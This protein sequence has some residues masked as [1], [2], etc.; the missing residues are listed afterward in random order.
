MKI[1]TMTYVAKFDNQIDIL[2][3][4]ENGL[5]QNLD[6]DFFIEDKSKKVTK[7]G[8]PKKSFG[9]QITIKSRTMTFNLKIFFNKKIQVTGVKSRENLDTIFNKLEHLFKI[10]I[11]SPKLVMK[12]CVANLGVNLNL[13][14]LFHHMKDVNLSVNYTPEIY[15]GLKLKHHDR[16]AMIFATGKVILSSKCE[17]DPVELLELVKQTVEVSRSYVFQND[18][19]GK[20]AHIA[21]A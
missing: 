6:K 3:I 12:N 1:S 7:K 15:P 13:F 16:T 18:P 2:S 14:K 10:K 4:Y 8:K 20:I 21:M 9:N 5:R 19:C 11:T 17:E